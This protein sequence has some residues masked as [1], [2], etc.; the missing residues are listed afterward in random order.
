MINAVFHGSLHEAKGLDYII[1]V[2]QNLK[3]VLTIPC[4]GESSKAIKYQPCTWNS[5]LKELIL[6]SEL[7]FVPSIW[8]CATEAAL[9]K[10][11]KL[12]LPV[13]VLNVKDSFISELPDSMVIKLTGTNDSDSEFLRKLIDD[14]SKLQSYGLNGLLWVEKFINEATLKI[15]NICA[16]L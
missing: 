12:G 11:L 13:V 2:I 3:I 10:T 5:G 1:D 14:R 7:V 15:P 4:E 6:D 8:S 9:L 16:E